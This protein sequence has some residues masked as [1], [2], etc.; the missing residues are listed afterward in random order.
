MEMRKDAL[1]AASYAVVSINEYADKMAEKTGGSAVATVGSLNVFPNGANVIPGRVEMV[2]DIRDVVDGNIEEMKEVILG[3]LHSLEVKYGVGMDIKIPVSH[4]A[5]PLSTEV[6]ETIEKAAKNLGIATKK[7]N[8]GAVHDAQNMAKKLKTGM[9]FVPSVRGI[10]HS[11]ME[12][13]E[14]DDI[15]TGVKLLTRTL[16]DL[17]KL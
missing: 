2:I 17:S 8:S 12:W 3:I 5:T 16:K 7:I 13:T 14:W 4:F 15:E 11:P 1:V 6:V 10:S 9:I